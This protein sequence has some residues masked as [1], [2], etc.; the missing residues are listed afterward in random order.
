MV[1]FDGE[2]VELESLSFTEVIT[3]LLDNL[4]NSLDEITAFCMVFYLTKFHIGNTKTLLTQTTK[5][6][7]FII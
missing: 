7:V 6:K 1:T 5:S 2:L 4:K 3:K